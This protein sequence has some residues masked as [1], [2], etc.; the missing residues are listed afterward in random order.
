MS[1]VE[2]VE[3]VG[4]GLVYEF[5]TRDTKAYVQLLLLFDAVWVGQVQPYHAVRAKRRGA[6][7]SLCIR[8]VS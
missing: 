6:L 8:L 3:A 4:G 5:T 2:S 1:A 7:Y